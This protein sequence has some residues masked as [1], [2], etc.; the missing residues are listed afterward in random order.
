MSKIKKLNVFFLPAWYP[1]S[2]NKIAGKFVIGHALAV[3]PSL[4]QLSVFYVYPYKNANKL[5]K[6]EVFCKDGINHLI[7]THKRFDG[8]LFPIS[9]LLYGFS[10]FYGYRKAIKL[11]GKPDINHVH[12]MTRLGVLALVM[13]YLYKTPYVITEHW[14]RY[15]LT[16]NGYK[17]TL[18]KIIT[19][20]VAKKSDGLSAVSENLL[21]AL[22]KHHII[23]KN[24]CVIR[25]AIDTD[26]Y[27]PKAEHQ[28]AKFKFLHVSGLEDKVKNVSGLLNAVRELNRL[29][30]DFELHIAGDHEDRAL[31]EKFVA[32]NQLYNVFF[33]GEIY[34]NELLRHYQEADVFVLFSNYENLP[35]VLLEAICAGMP[36]ISSEVGGTAEIVNQN[37]GLLVKAKDEKALIRAMQYM[38]QNHKQYDR[39]IIR[40]EAVEKYAYKSVGE[41]MMKFYHSEL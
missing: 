41:Q 19:R 16:V 7:I 40:Q 34:G 21:M 12:V 36:V 11:F 24:T 25:N 2:D 13:K 28:S 23:N 17:G 5:F 33:Y 18:R 26:F 27:K 29:A 14:S 20:M 4:K 15:L 30:L 39:E 9:F 35:C 38:L 10:L 32:D 3:L 31:F 22:K 6:Q 37:N 8:L 1:N